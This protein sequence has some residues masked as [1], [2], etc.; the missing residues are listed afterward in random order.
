MISGFV[1]RDLN[2]D[3]TFDDGSV[4]GLAGVTISLS[5]TDHLGNPVSR[6]AVTNSSGRYQFVDLRPGNY[7]V[8]ETQPTGLLNGRDTVGTPTYGA[9]NSN[10]YDNSLG[11]YSIAV[12]TPSSSSDDNNFGELPPAMLSG[13]V[14]VDANN[15][16]LRTGEN[17][18]PMV[19]IS[20]SGID[21]QGNSVN[22]TATTDASGAYQFTDLRPGTYQVEESQPV[23]YVD[24]FETRGNVVPIAG[25]AGGPDTIGG[26]SL[27][28]GQ[29]AANNN[30]GELPPGQIS[31]RVFADINNDGLLNGNDSGL[32]G[33]AL[34]L[35]GTDVNGQAVTRMTTTDVDG[36]YEFNGLVG[37]TYTVAEPTQ[38]NGYFDGLEAR[39]GVLQPGSIGTDAINGIVLPIGGSI[40]E[41][42]FAEVPVVDPHGFVYIDSNNNGIR[43]AGEVGIPGVPVELSGFGVDVFGN[44]VTPQTV[45]TDQ[46]GFYRF[47][48]LS[49]G[50]YTITETQPFGFQDGQ[51]E[52]GTPAAQIV[53]NDQFVG[54]DL[55]NQTDG[56]DYNFGELSPTGRLSGSVY[57]D[58]DNNGQRGSGEIGLAGVSVTIIDQNNP[59]TRV[60]VVTDAN[61]DYQFVKMFPG[62]YR[63]EESQPI[64]FIDG[65]E[66]AG[67]RGGNIGNDVISD[68]T[69]GVGQS[70]SGYLFG[71]LGVRLDLISK[72]D[73]LSSTN[74]GV[75]FTGQ[76]GSGIAAVGVPLSDPSGFVY[77]DT[78]GSGQRDEGEPGIP[79]VSIRLTGLGTD[80]STIEQQVLT[81]GDGFYQFAFLPPGVYSLH[82]VQPVGYLDGSE[83]IGS[84]GG[85]V[86][87]DAFTEIVLREGDIGVD[88]NFGERLPDFH[89]GDIN[90]NGAV[91]ADDLD[92]FCEAVRNGNSW[93]DLNG[94]SRVN[95]EDLLYLVLNYVGTTPGDANLDGQFDSSD[96][97]Q[98]FL[99]GGYEDQ[100]IGNSGWDS[101]DWNCD[102]EF[103]SADFV[104]SLQFGD[105]VLSSRPLPSVA[106]ALVEH[107]LRAN[108]EIETWA[109]DQALE[110]LSEPADRTVDLLF[111]EENPTRTEQAFRDLGGK[112]ARADSDDV[113]SQ[114]VDGVMHDLLPDFGVGFE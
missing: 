94:D 83:T 101:G 22:R 24:G 55:T 71:E 40:A 45:F 65:M 8:N 78:N 57:V 95:E 61:G 107:G 30:F 7:T 67:S 20:L 111:V 31:G 10:R 91:Q 93:Y 63:L 104:L 43:D 18:I 42:R 73:F 60:T 5:G 82:E 16:G 15:D 114:A 110:M 59:G 112:H 102:A 11:T 69:I 66:T 38:P 98:V 34:V 4:N 33:I 68:I 56:G 25:S 54:I 87:Q 36:N 27:V 37:G 51:E 48:N 84:H 46:D 41:N 96:L 103:S 70:S 49:P 100:T 79:N 39:N 74:P 113:L 52:N 12:G 32:A 29:T 1:Y 3:G 64:N 14:F 6:S 28:P 13:S 77:V 53:N 80:G 85:I 106:G 86:G 76:P 88:Y 47:A 35:N 2:N 97:V 23:S 26:I 50:Q 62:T 9:V 72:R 44:V 89:S 108:A 19:T 109:Y 99:S 21:D 75:D 90:E 105:F 92:L 58:Q 81:N 17:G